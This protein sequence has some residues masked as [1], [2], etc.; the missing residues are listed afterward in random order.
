MIGGRVV[1]SMIAVAVI[2]VALAG[3]AGAASSPGLGQR[4]PPTTVTSPEDALARVVAHEPRLTGIQPFDSGLVG[5]SS[6]YTVEPA[7]GVGAFLVTVRIGWGDCEAG[8]IDEHTWVLAV[9]PDGGVS[10][11]S[12]TGQPIPA[13]AWPSPIGAGKTGIAGVALAGPVCPVESVPP[14]PGC[15]PRP[16][17]GAVVLIRDRAGSEVARVE[18]AA[19]GS[20]FAELPAGDYVVEPQP[21]EGLMGTAGAVSVTVADGLVGRVQLDY[22]TGIR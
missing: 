19:D 14:D 17:A 16:V 20:F 10:V 22:D 3:C 11:V 9:T 4:P 18:T 7:S 12:E 1:R 2:A 6:W 21:V 5:Q 15:A 13:D 8:C